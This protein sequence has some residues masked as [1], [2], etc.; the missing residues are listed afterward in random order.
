[1]AFVALA[2]L[3]VVVGVGCYVL[4]LAARQRLVHELTEAAAPAAVGPAAA[5]PAAGG[6]RGTGP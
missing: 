5:T 6:G 1:M 2:Y 4:T 3:A